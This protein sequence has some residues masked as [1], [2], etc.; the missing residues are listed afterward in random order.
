MANN[1]K[2]LTIRTTPGVPAVPS[3]QAKRKGPIKK[4]LEEEEFTEVRYNSCKKLNQRV[5][6]HCA[7][8]TF[9][10]R[11]SLFS[12]IGPNNHRPT[13]LLS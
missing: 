8:I 13:R 1:S 9:E 12:F 2:A 3:G 6:L 7:F 4:A 10:L 11:H 5:W